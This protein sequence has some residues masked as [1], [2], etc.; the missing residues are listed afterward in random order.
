MSLIK[1]TK[2]ANQPNT[3]ES[4]NLIIIVLKDIAVKMFDIHLQPNGTPA[5][6]IDTMNPYPPNVVNIENAMP[7]PNQATTARIMSLIN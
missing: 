7:K 5:Q 6:K 4:I 1:T 2:I 3:K